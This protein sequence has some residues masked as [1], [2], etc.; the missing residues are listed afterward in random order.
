MMSRIPRIISDKY[1][2]LNLPEESKV[3][4]GR[5]KMYVSGGMVLVMISIGV[6]MGVRFNT[7]QNDAMVRDARSNKIKF[8][9]DDIRL[10]GNVIPIH[11]RIYLHPNITD[12]KFGFTGNVR[13]LLEVKKSTNSIILH[14][15][16][17]KIISTE[18]FEDEDNWDPEAD[19]D[20]DNVRVTVSGT[21]KNQKHEMLMVQLNTVLSEQK[22]YV[23][24]VSFCG[25]LSNGLDGFYKS[26]YKTKKGKRR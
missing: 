2:D 20:K 23:L 25:N 21:P 13:I 22:R 24:S 7:I 12:G 10:P 11:Y 5:W 6:A 8:P 17:L 19:Y 9:Y 3:K 15:K 1:E 26:S 18:L 4:I 16:S 14:S